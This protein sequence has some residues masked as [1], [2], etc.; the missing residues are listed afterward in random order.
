MAI[1][2]SLVAVCVM[3]VLVVFRVD[4]VLLYR[5]VTGKDETLEGKI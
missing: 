2:F 4:L 3:I 5:D 1:L